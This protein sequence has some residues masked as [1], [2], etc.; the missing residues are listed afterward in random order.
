MGGPYCETCNY[1]YPSLLSNDF[2]ECL[3][4]SKIIHA[5]HGDRINSPPEVRKTYECCNHTGLKSN[6]PIKPTA[7]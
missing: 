6:K 7:K 1:F 3:D 2:G 4:P 5:K